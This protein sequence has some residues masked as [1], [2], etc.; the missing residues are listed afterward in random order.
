MGGSKPSR[1]QYQAPQYTELSLP[2]LRTALEKFVGQDQDFGRLQNTVLSSAQKKM[3]ALETLRPGYKAGIDTAQQ[4]ADSMARGMIPAD[5]ANKISR[6]SAF[7]GLVTGLPG[8]Q[9]QAIEARDLGLTS[10][11]MQG[12]GLAAQQA[13]R[14]EANA[15]MPMQ[16]M[17]LAFM[18]QQI[19]AEDVS[20]A[21]YNNQIKNQQAT[22]NANN[23]N[24]QQE[25][26]YEYDSKYGG[27]QWGAIGGGILGA[28]LGV[29]AAPATGGL[30]IPMGLSMGS[31]LGGSF[32]GGQ[33]FSMANALGGIGT[34]GGN[35]M[36]TMA[37]SGYE[38]P[39][40]LGGPAQAYSPTMRASVGL[41][42]GAP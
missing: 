31:A 32:G 15:M 28:G 20:L 38:F 21:Q 7:K 37:R 24:R 25:A 17:N 10:L 36:A 35:M 9:R 30:S 3:D 1:P 2:E 6:S 4:A 13:L 23:Y 34:A 39:N 41:R 29:L 27:S 19:R 12:R 5:V 16:A 18:P 40:F 11:D 22:A 14:V 42:S 33:G 26:N 8:E